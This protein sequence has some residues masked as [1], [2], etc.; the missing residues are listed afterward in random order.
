MDLNKAL[1]RFVAGL[2]KANP[3]MTEDQIAQTAQQKLRAA[4]SAPSTVKE[5][6]KARPS[7]ARALRE[8]PL[9]P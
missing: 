1:G 7:G 6:A 8:I 2:R 5:H 9:A 3:G 4:L